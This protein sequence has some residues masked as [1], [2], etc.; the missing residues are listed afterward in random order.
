MK[1]FE[2]LWERRKDAVAKIREFSDIRD[3]VD[4]RFVE[5]FS[6]AYEKK[7][8]ELPKRTHFDISPFEDND[9]LKRFLDVPEGD[10]IEVAFVD[11]LERDVYDRAVVPL[12]EFD[13]N[14]IKSKYLVTF[15]DKKAEK[16]KVRREEAERAEF[17]RLKKKYGN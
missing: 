16:E 11:S 13:K 9:H 15:E 10:A 8:G 2:E 4:A 14:E 3:G 17:E 6:K 5:A 1:K 7:H 12:S